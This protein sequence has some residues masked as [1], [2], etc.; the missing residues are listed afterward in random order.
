MS[1]VGVAGAAARRCSCSAPGRTASTRPAKRRRNT[2]ASASPPIPTNPG[3][4]VLMLDDAAP[5]LRRPPR[6]DRSQI[7]LRAAGSPKRSTPSARR[8]TPMDVVFVGGGGFTLPRWL[9]ATRPGSPASCSRSTSE[10]VEFDEEHLGLQRSP[11]LR[12]DDRRRPRQHARRPRRQRRRRRRRR[13]RQPGD[14]LAPGHGR[15]DRRSQ[16]RAEAGRPLRAQ[17]DRRTAARPA[18]RPRRQRVL[19]RLP[20]RPHRHQRPNWNTRQAATPSS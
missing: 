6:S 2:T 18:A 10:L 20:P 19:E 16:A 7:R 17:R 3:G 11:Q 8:K 4:Y 13:L 5:L 14:P 9:E 12:I 1:L 15:V